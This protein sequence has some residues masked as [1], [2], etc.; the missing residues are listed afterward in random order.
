MNTRHNPGRALP[1][2][3]IL[4][5]AFAAGLGLWLLTQPFTAAGPEMKALTRYPTPRAVADFRLTRSDGRPLTRTDL[6]GHW[7]V[8]FFGFTNCPDIC[9]STLGVLKQVRAQLTQAGAADKVAIHFVSVDPQ[10]DQ[11]DV[12]G[13]Y[14]AYYDPGFVAATGSD[15]ELTRLTRSLGVLYVREPATNGQYSVDHSASIAVVD[16]QARLVGLFRP[17]LDA[18]AIGADL[19]T[20]ANSN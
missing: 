10:R 1:T 17:P 12:L 2:V 6:Q 16:P 7:S 20:L 8:F 4:V 3:L 18:A 14:A 19:L 9:P 5:A 15:E 13:R 11:P